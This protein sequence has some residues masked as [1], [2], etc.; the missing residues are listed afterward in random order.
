[1]RLLSGLEYPYASESVQVTEDFFS[2]GRGYKHDEYWKVN[3]SYCFYIN[4]FVQV[5]VDEGE[6]NCNSLRERSAQK[7]LKE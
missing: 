2:S 4:L 6:K 3:W 1:M 5:P 7:V